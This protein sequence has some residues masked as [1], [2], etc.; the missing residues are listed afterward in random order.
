MTLVFDGI[1]YLDLINSRSILK[2]E[3][4]TIQEIN[5]K[6]RYFYFFDVYKQKNKFSVNMID[7]L[8]GPLPLNTTKACWWCT[9][10]FDTCP[11][12]IPIF[13]HQSN[14][15]TEQIFKNLNL[16]STD[17]TEHFETEGI[18]CSF[19]CA[20][21][22][23]IDQKFTSKYK[24]ST[25]LLSLLYKYIKGSVS[26]IPLAPSWKLLKKFGGEMSI[27]EFRNSFGEFEYIDCQNIKKPL[28]FSVGNMYIEK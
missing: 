17:G 21:S 22:Y 12:G 20:K 24:N 7:Y 1:N 6:K 28:I 19:P 5:L 3:V 4:T 8:N 10:S 27:T 16:N 18:F 25:V 14:K 13:Y 2:E 11:I 23:I 26:D 15:K 9:H